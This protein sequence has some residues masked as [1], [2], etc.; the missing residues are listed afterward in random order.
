MIK[1]LLLV[2][3][4]RLDWQLIRV[5]SVNLQISE[6]NSGEDDEATPQPPPITIK[7]RM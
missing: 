6:I 1:L 4:V 2:V 3:V 5:R 7:P